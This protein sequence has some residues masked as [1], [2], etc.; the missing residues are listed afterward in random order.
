MIAGMTYY[1]IC[2]YF[3]IYSFLG[4]LAE[5]IYHA[6]HLGKIVNRGFLCGPVCPVY[7]FGMLAVLAAG[8]GI[9]TAVEGSA[10]ASASGLGTG[11]LFL[12]G[13]VL[14]TLIELVAGWALDKIFHARWWDYS[15][16]FLNFHGYICLEFSIIWGIAVV[17]AV[18]VLHRDLAEHTAEVIDPSIGWPVMA[19]LYAIYLFDFIVTVLTVR[20]MNRELSELDEIRKKLRIPSDRLS[21]F[22][23][24]NSLETIQKVQYAQ[25]QADLGR[26]ELGDAIDEYTGE[27]K[28]RM[29]ERAIQFDEY[30]DEQKRKILNRRDELKAMLRQHRKTGAVRLLRAFPD[31]RHEK[32]SDLIEALKEEDPDWKKN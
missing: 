24:E 30:T 15:G 9:E 14:T 4:W 10:S 5:V 26:K 3:L 11:W 21:T 16:K 28:E 13:M 18:K 31:M 25:V 19:V 27:Q 17:L 7:G 2:M 12:M 8:N 22:V 23:G 6:V 20:G 32:F 1:Q 29:R